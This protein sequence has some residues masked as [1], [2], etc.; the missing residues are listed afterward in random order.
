MKYILS[1]G[2]SKTGGTGD[3]V[4]S[5][6]GYQAPLCRLLSDSTHQNWSENPPRIGVGGLDMAALAARVDADIAAM[7]V[8]PHEILIN[9]GANDSGAGFNKA[10]W[11]A[12]YDYTI[13]AYHTAFPSANIRLVKIWIRDAGGGDQ[14]AAMAGQHEV[15]NE[16]Y[17]SYSWLKTGIN[18]IFLENGDDGATYTTDGTHPNFDG[19]ALEA[20]AWETAIAGA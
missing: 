2:D 11:K 9:M 18:E 8:T 7:T 14:T 16:L 1:V 5:P 10:T 13:N 15:I 6:P 4:G 20:A 12:G 3:T 17:T 19:Y